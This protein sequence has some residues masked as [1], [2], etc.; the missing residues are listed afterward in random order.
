M[1]I[2]EINGTEKDKNFN[3]LATHPL[4]SW[5]WGE[6]RKSQS[7]KVVRIGK[8]ENQILKEVSQISF[9]STPL[10]S[11]TVGYL[12]KG[13]FPNQEIIEKLKQIGK[14]NKAIFIR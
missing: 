6:F 3:Q 4:Q 1:K 13:P 7:H 9:H 10:F 5:E 2:I 8:E 14:E 12:P 11:Q